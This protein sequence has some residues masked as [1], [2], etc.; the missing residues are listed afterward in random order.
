MTCWVE[1]GGM[2]VCW[3]GLCM[4]EP[5][6]ASSLLA[7]MPAEAAAGRHA[8]REWR[9]QSRMCGGSSSSSEA[10]WGTT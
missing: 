9:Q 1:R 7:P 10:Q 2:T 6:L 4:A 5:I 8:G 3:L